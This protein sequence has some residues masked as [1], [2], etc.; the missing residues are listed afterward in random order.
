[1]GQMLLRSYTALYPANAT[2]TVDGSEVNYA[3][4]GAAP[5]FLNFARYAA[6]LK[7]ISDGEKQFSV[8]LPWILPFFAAW[9][10]LDAM[11]AEMPALSG[12]SG[13]LSVGLQV[14][15]DALSVSVEALVRN[16]TNSTEALKL[17]TVIELS[18]KVQ[19]LFARADTYSLEHKLAVDAI[20]DL[21]AA[22]DL[23]SGF[24]ELSSL[25]AHLDALRNE[26]VKV[27]ALHTKQELCKLDPLTTKLRAELDNAETEEV[28][29]FA[30]RALG[31]ITALQAMY[32]ELKPGE[33]RSQLSAKCQK[34]FMRKR[35]LS[36]DPHISICFDGLANNVSVQDD[37]LIQ[38]MKEAKTEHH[39]PAAAAF[40]VPDGGASAPATPEED[41]YS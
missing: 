15:I 22:V 21:R 11:F 17:P 34:G 24:K 29:S 41:L 19:A 20:L 27:K 32:R 28:R 30:G 38:K 13:L 37:A 23:Y 5:A 6:E 14:G 39:E 9:A 1:M 33:T 10:L 3:L 8:L 40:F 18:A 25:R 31:N 4:L 7:A 2:I 36:I 16:W 12:W 35:W 26:L